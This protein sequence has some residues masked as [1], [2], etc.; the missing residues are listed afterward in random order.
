MQSSGVSWLVGL[1]ISAS[2]IA[3]LIFLYRLALKGAAAPII[4]SGSTK[5]SSSKTSE[6]SVRRPF[7]PRKQGASL[8]TDEEVRW[9]ELD[10]KSE[11]DSIKKRLGSNGK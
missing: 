2:L 1:L 11:V 8:P 7:Q 3:L 4:R 6:P 10:D 5:S 9:L